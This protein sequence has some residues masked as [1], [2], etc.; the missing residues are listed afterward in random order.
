VFSA[1]KNEKDDTESKIIYISEKS[2]ETFE[3]RNK[4]AC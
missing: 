3:K 4:K 2:R 1:T